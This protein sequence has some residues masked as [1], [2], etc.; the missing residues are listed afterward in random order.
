[1]IQTMQDVAERCAL[2]RANRV[3][4][5]A[6]GLYPITLSTSEWKRLSMTSTFIEMNVENA[7]PETLVET[8]PTASW[9]KLEFRQMGVAF[10]IT[11]D[12]YEMTEANIQIGTLEIR[13]RADAQTN[14]ILWTPTIGNDLEVLID[15]E[16][17][18]HIE[19]ALLFIEANKIVKFTAHLVL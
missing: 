18:H 10:Y 19:R 9:K 5:G 8:I 1:M 17:V 4:P 16:R 14:G 15:G 6:D 12:T 7:Q 13:R 11:P 3:P 2:L